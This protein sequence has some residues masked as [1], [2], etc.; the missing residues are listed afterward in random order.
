M[1]NI[2]HDDDCP[3]CTRNPDVPLLDYATYCTH[4]GQDGIQGCTE[5]KVNGEPYCST[6]CVEAARDRRIAMSTTYLVTCDQEQATLAFCDVPYCETFIKLEEVEA[7]R[8]KG[9][10]NITW[11]KREVA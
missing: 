4:C 8:A 1:S 5:H 6:K 10:V 9:H 2:A 7:H 11:L 3:A